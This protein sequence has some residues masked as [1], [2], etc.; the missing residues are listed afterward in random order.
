MANVEQFFMWKNSSD[1]LKN[2]DV[3]RLSRSAPPHPV[4]CLLEHQI[5]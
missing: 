3:S 5:P 4:G 2:A 1:Y